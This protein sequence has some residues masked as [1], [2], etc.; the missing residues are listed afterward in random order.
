LGELLSKLQVIKSTGDVE[1]AEE[2]FDRFGTKVRSD[3]KTNIVTRKEKLGIP[4]LKAFVFPQLI[5]VMKDDKLA[6][7]KIAF[8][9]DL[10]TQ[11]LRFRRLQYTTDIEVK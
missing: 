3:W 9:E 7:V 11:H 5:P 10:T 6:D 4:K 1:A 2:L 8:D